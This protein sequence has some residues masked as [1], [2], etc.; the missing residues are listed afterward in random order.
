MYIDFPYRYDRRGA[1][2]TT[3]FADHVRDLIEQL[4]FTA[5]GERINRPDFGCGLAQL[6]F[7][8]NS[9]ELAAAVQHTVQGAIAQWLG[10]VVD[11]RR[12]EVEARESTLRVALDYALI[13]T[14]E[15]RSDVF[16][17]EVAP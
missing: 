4:L 14:G 11:V 2:A 3:D 7:A 1:T 13:A 5:P 12:L 10:D 9:P 6:V 16:V 15:A 8:P 17:R